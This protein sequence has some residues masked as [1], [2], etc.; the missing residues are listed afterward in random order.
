[1]IIVK[2]IAIVT[3]NIGGLIVMFQAL[4]LCINYVM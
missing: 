2:V 3:S 1:M 4:P